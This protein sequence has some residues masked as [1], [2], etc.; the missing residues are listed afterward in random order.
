MLL[1]RSGFITGDKGPRLQ[2]NP[3]GKGRGKFIVFNVLNMKTCV[4]TANGLRAG[5]VAVRCCNYAVWKNLNG[6]VVSLGKKMRLCNKISCNSSW[7]T[8]TRIL[9]SDNA[10]DSGGALWGFM[11]A[12]QEIRMN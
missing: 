11:L 7:V 10:G 12:P 5:S 2:I 4:L 9:S 1:S 3:P 6:L 8:T